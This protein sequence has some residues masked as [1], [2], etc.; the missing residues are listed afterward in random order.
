MRTYSQLARLR[1]FDE[2]FE[3]L[4]LGAAVGEA[5]FGHERW[6]NQQFYR[7][8]EWRDVRDEV[9]ARDLGYDLGIEGRSIMKQLHVHHMN[10]IDLPDLYDFNPDVLR[11]EYLVTVSIQTHNAIHY[12]SEPP[13]PITFADRRPGDTTPWKRSNHESGMERA[14]SR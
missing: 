5:T 11:P 9:I 7:S 1:T 6:L 10:P 3:Y 12:G 13:E 2:R 4:K 8:R 14:R